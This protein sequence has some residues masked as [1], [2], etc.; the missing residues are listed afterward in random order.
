MKDKAELTAEDEPELIWGTG[1]RLDLY[2]SGIAPERY[3]VQDC[4]RANCPGHK[5]EW[6]RHDD[7]KWSRPSHIPYDQEDGGGWRVCLASWLVGGEE[8]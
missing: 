3:E 5:H 1:S 8:E 2:R 6:N 4:D 7:G